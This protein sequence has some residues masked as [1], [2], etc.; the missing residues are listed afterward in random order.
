[1]SILT[2][3]VVSNSLRIASVFASNAASAATNLSSI[4]TTFAP[5]FSFIA[6]SSRTAALSPENDATVPFP[7]AR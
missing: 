1:M 4:S 6:R 3:S 5:S 2:R 7:L